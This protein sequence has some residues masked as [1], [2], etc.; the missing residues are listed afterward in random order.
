MKNLNAMMN[1]ECIFGSRV[2]VMSLKRLEVIIEFR[3][4]QHFRSF[5]EI[6]NSEEAR[7]K[8]EEVSVLVDLIHRSG[9]ETMAMQVSGSART[10][11][12]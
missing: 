1:R 12:D 3:N 10:S 5:S 7:Q 4:L 11:F 6:R 8:K 2:W 9:Q